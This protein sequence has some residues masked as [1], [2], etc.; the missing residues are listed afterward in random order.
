MAEDHSRVKHPPLDPCRLTEIVQYEC[1]FS[2][3]QLHCY[4]IPRIFRMLH[5]SAFYSVKYLT[6]TLPSCRNRPA[7]EITRSVNIDMNTGAVEIPPEAR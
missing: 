5:E 4:P 2:S 6:E 3:K 1:E 7:V